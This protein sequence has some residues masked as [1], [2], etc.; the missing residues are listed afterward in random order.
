MAKLFPPIVE[1]TIPA[2]YSNGMVN[3]T[4]PFSM[5]KAVNKNQVKGIAVKV[6]TLQSSSYL[7]VNENG[8]Y[9]LDGS[10]YVIITVN[11]E[12][13]TLG[14]FYKFQIAYIDTSN[15]I[16]YYSNVIVGKYTSQPTIGIDGLEQNK[17]NNHVYTYYGY[18]KNNDVTENV[19]SYKFDLYDDIDQLVVT[20]GELIHDNSNDDN[21]GESTDIFVLSR[22]L[23]NKVYYLQYTITT[24]NDLILQTEKYALKQSLS[25]DTDI[26]KPILEAIIDDTARENGI[27]RISLKS[28]EAKQINGNF[29]LYR[30][31]ESSDFLDW[32]EYYRFSLNTSDK[33]NKEKLWEDKTVQHGKKYKYAIAQYNDTGLYSEKII[34]EKAIEI[35]F[36]D[37]FLCD[38]NRQLKIRFNPKIPSFKNTNLETK[39]ETVGSKH[40][41]IL[42]NGRVSYKEFPISGLIS[43]LMDTDNTF[44]ENNYTRNN[45]Y[46]KRTQDNNEEISNELL[47]DLTTNNI[48]KE[49]NFKT[50]VLDWLTNGEPK[51]FRSPTEGNFIVRLMNI[52]LT[53]TD[54]LGRMLHTFNCT[55]YEIAECNY[56][57][58]KSL[59]VV[60]LNS[61]NEIQS[62]YWKTIDL[63]DYSLSENLIPSL[64]QSIRFY[65]M[66]PGTKISINFEDGNTQTIEIGSTGQYILESGGTPISGVYLFN[67]NK[68]LLTYS[69]Y[70]TIVNDF[71]TYSN[72]EVF[73]IPLQQFI[74]ETDI[75]KEILYINDGLNKNEKLSIISIPRIKVTKR[76]IVEI[77]KDGNIY[78]RYNGEHEE[79]IEK[80]DYSTLY[81]I[82][83][84]NDQNILQ[85]LGYNSFKQIFNNNEL[86]WV[87][88]NE[89]EA[90]NYDFSITIGSSII[91]VEDT[92][93]FLYKAK[94][95]DFFKVIIGYN[96]KGSPIKS[97]ELYIKAGNG[98]IT[99]LTYIL[100]SNEFLI[101]NQTIYNVASSRDQYIQ[102]QANLENLYNTGCSNENDDNAR[103]EFMNSIITQ[104][105]I[106]KQSYEN[107]IN[108]LLSERERQ[109]L[110]EGTVNEK[111][112]QY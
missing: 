32:E 89:I 84:Y 34:T 6:K 112:K 31:D 14:Q 38:A 45:Y 46:R 43:Y 9:S 59:G 104:Q 88:V 68:G 106:V 69:F 107:Y 66:V 7:F 103:L 16:G 100:K 20:S 29:I 17:N 97:D 62:L 83:E 110:V 75:I 77:R 22:D 60:Q 28:Q 41:F 73:E 53:P 30:S 35:D 86:K 80:F 55:A 79:Q 61:L 85:K 109:N 47:T 13:F 87:P 18:Y 94:D 63:N 65:D 1:G 105:E 93:D 108:T 102:E 98:V 74:G 15:E 50:E 78:Y 54:S 90:E 96:E 40:P 57:N 11:A 2:F 81:C 76:P 52:S 39:I 49:R 101:E 92:Y 24:I 33:V 51:L 70:Q 91:N 19:Y 23:G 3:I 48:I 36:E 44:I 4:I 56:E 111:Q 27:V 21:L 5:N 37:S 12:Q 95:L 25:I 26:G 71:N 99:E 82:Y 58:L 10:P 67:N 42:R 72:V 64:V 8:I